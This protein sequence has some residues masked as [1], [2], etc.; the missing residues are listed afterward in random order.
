MD[1]DGDQ[2]LDVRHASGNAVSH[3]LVRADQIQTGKQF[4]WICERAEEKL[5]C[6]RLR[7][8]RSGPMLV[9]YPREAED[10]LPRTGWA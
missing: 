1:Q 6:G 4:D 5:G 3:V 10:G 2:H 7:A 8:R 9:L